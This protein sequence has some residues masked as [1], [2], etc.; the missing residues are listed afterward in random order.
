[1]RLGRVASFTM[2]VTGADATGLTGVGFVHLAGRFTSSAEAWDA[3]ESLINAA[4]PDHATLDVLGEFAIAPL[5]GPPSRDFQTLH[6]TSVCPL[7]PA[8]PADTA[9]FTAL[10]VAADAPPSAAATRL[11]SLRALLSARAWP[12]RSELVRRFAA[13][14]ETHGA[15]NH[16]A[17]YAEGSLANCSS[18]TI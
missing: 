12:D 2:P 17:G 9:L 14:G 8:V 13:Y 16:T 1:M 7:V 10:H 11:V 18:S 3:A 4:S 6:Q 5:H 15:W